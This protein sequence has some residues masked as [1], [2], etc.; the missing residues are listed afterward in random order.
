[1]IDLELLVVFD[2]ENVELPET[3]ASDLVAFERKFGVA[4]GSLREGFTM[5]QA[6][7]IIWRGLLRAGTIDPGTPFDESF[8]DRIDDFEQRRRPFDPPPSAPSGAPSPDS[9][10]EPASPLESSSTLIPSSS[11]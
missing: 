10:T 4:W 3:R 5:E 1:M 6:C 9:P 11:T 8:L 2:G 7:F